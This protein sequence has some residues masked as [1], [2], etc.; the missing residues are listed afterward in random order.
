MTMMTWLGNNKLK[1]SQGLAILFH[2][3]GCIGIL[4]TPYREWFIAHTPLNL[5]LMFLLL[6]WNQEGKEAGFII[7]LLISFMV[8]MGTEM[9]GVNTGKLFGCYRYGTVM[10]PKLNGVPWLIGVNWFVVTYS[11]GIIMHKLLERLREK[12]AAAGEHL[13]TSLA[14]WS[15][16]VDGA[17]LAVLFDWVME[18]VAMKLGF[19]HWEGEQIPFFNYLTWFV[20]SIFLMLLFRTLRFNKDNHFAIH[21]FIIQTLFFIIIR[22]SL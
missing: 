2:V 10:G 3:C 9:I 7:F 8:G 11:S 15:F 22:T 13:S 17:L 5:L 21:L 6:I 1:L 12:Y 19:W 4:F 20:I 18:P 14:K 16:I